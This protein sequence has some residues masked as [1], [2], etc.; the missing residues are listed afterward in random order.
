[1]SA[2][3]QKTR[4]LQFYTDL[5]QRIGATAEAGEQGGFKEE[6]FTGI[7]LDEYLSST[8]DTENARECC[9]VKENSAGHKMHKIN[10]Y[11]LSE[12]YENLDLFVTIYKGFDEPQRI[13]REEV[14]T[15]FNQCRRFLNDAFK[16]YWQQMGESAP[17]FDFAKEVCHNRQSL[18]RANLFLLTDGECTIE[19]PKPDRLDNTELLLT[20]R[21]VDINYLARIDQG[22]PEPIV[23]D[24]E[25]RMAKTLPC[26]AIPTASD[27]YETYL[28]AVPGDVLANIY[29]EYGA[30]L[31]E[32]NVR[33]FLQ[34]T[35]GTNKGIR[36]TILKEPALFLAYNIGIAATAD[37]VELTAD[38]RAIKSLTGLQIVN[39]GQTT[40]SIFYTQR[41]D[42]AD[43]SQI[44]VQMKLSVIKTRDDVGTIV[45]NISRYANTQNKVSESDLSANNPFHI[46]FEKLSRTVWTTIP[47]QTQQTH[48]FYERAR[49]QYKNALAREFSVTNK[50]RFELQNPRKQLFVKEDLAKYINVW[51]E[52]PWFVVRGSQKNFAEFGK[53]LKVKD[54]KPTT[55]FFEDTIAKAIL[56]RTAEEV[57]GRQPRAIGDLRYVTVPYTLAWLS[58]TLAGKLDLFKIW[59]RQQLSEA[60]RTVL[61]DLMVAVEQAVKASATGALYGEWAKKEDCW[62]HIRSQQF[63]LGITAIKSDLIDPT[64]PIIR[65]QMTDDD[66]ETAQQKATAVW[67]C[68][69]PAIIWDQIAEWGRITE[70]LTFNQRNMAAG[71]AHEIRKNSTLAPDKLKT[72]EISGGELILEKIMAEAPQLLQN[73]PDEIVFP[74]EDLSVQPPVFELTMDVIRRAIAFDKSRKVLKIPSH[75]FL[76][77]IGEGKRTLNDTNRGAIQKLV[78]TLSKWG[79]QPTQTH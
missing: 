8:G 53:S 6:I 35:V 24:F 51:N 73:M 55:V 26:L 71:V 32:M 68:S 17:A 2:E 15:A 49:A 64:K 43:V 20:Y 4:L 66:M 76:K 28:A 45:N 72:Q 65:Q 1:M 30:R 44:F 5:R 19:P 40:A 10:G 58:K 31:L 25:K 75:V 14:T 74:S 33:S 16:G 60:M 63:T 67:L 3:Q 59:K 13:G 36:Q 56:F 78:S 41:K 46:E 47:G 50:K 39:G 52:L 23:I 70:K 48:W 42:K 38:R 7:I 79:F 18:V 9:D 61:Y 11:A 77:E 12:S 27:Q 22:E 29:E 69:V 57:Y 21:I 34:F 54:L 37:A 62:K